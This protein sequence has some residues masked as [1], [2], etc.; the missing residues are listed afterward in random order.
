MRYRLHDDEHR[1]SE[2]IGV[3]MTVSVGDAGDQTITILSRRGAAIDVS[4]S[5]VIV[6][7]LFP[8]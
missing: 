2:A 6:A 7:K 4:S 5:D 1:I 3:V 8:L